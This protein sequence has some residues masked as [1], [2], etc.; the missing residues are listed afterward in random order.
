MSYFKD[1]TSASTLNNNKNKNFTNF[2]NENKASGPLL[3]AKNMSKEEKKF[4][5]A[6]YNFIVVFVIEN[7][8]NITFK[9]ICIARFKKNKYNK[10][11]LNFI[12]NEINRLNKE[13]PEFT[14]CSYTQFKDSE[15]YK[16]ILAQW[17]GSDTA[18]KKLSYIFSIVENYAVKAI[19][20][21]IG[22]HPI[23][24]ALMYIPV[25]IFLSLLGIRLTESSITD[26]ICEFDGNMI[27]FNID[28]STKGFVISNIYL[29]MINENNN[30]AALKMD[31]PPNNIYDLSNTQISDAK[32]NAKSKLKIIIDNFK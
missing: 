4:Y 16:R 17:R 21:S 2:Y 25:K 32:E 5:N 7:F 19:S 27:K 23:I 13:H 8:V 6:L 9:N 24:S 20:H 26:I 15:I 29:Y 14:K 12:S 10:D 11:F 28:I 3:T 30:I 18:I 1:I 31:T 22:I